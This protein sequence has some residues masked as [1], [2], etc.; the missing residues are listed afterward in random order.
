MTKRTSS[1]K[2]S[3]WNLIRL[4]CSTRLRRLI[5]IF[6][7]SIAK[8]DDGHLTDNKGR[9]AN[10][11]NTIIIMTS[12]MGSEIILENFGIWMGRQ[13]SRTEIIETTKVEVFEKL[14]ESLRPEF[15]NRIDD[16]IM[17]YLSDQDGNQ[18]NCI[19][20]VKNHWRRICSIKE[21]I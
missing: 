3:R 18:E 10:F 15:L 7:Y 8:L 9:V 2:R 4:S 21:L 19:L 16:K 11:K 1:P 14:K 13:T 20:T 12:N 6:Q 5:R 17:F